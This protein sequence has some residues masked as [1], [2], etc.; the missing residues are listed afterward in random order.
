MRGL[1]SAGLGGVGVVLAGVLGLVAG[2]VVEA[3]AFLSASFFFCSAAASF[4]RSSLILCWSGEE[5]VG[6][7]WR[8][9]R[10]PAWL[11]GGTSG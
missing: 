1:G 3:L 11:W 10:G 6:G 5:V 2:G 9:V 4:S 7:D 8:E